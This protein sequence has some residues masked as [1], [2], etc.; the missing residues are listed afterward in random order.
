MKTSAVVLL[1]GGTIV[2]SV[3]GARL[4]EAHPGVVGAGLLLLATALVLARRSSGGAAHPVRG[5]TVA[6]FTSR[7]G[8]LSGEL[9]ALAEEA[10]RLSLEQIGQRIA[11]LEPGHFRPL[12]DDAPL[13]MDVL[14]GDRFADFAGTYAAGERLVSRAWSAAVDQHRPETLVSLKAG[15][16]AVRAAHRS[17]ASALHA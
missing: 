17:L 12:A 8:V 3:G 1:V 10:P 4:P 9:D 13:L 5:G 16:E 14:G 15:A 2:A 6:G 11:A 7:L